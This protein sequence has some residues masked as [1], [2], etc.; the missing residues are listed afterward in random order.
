MGSPSDAATTETDRTTDLIEDARQ[1][2]GSD[3]D[4]NTD[5]D[6]DDLSPPISRTPR[7]LSQFEE[8]E[9][10]LAKHSDCFY[11]AKVI[12]INK[13]SYFLKFRV[14]VPLILLCDL[15]SFLFFSQVLNVEYKV[16]EWKYFVHYIVSRYFEYFVCR[17]KKLRHLF[18]FQ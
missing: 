11:E 6:G 15:F 1:D 3:T 9:K 7:G 12:K 17:I 10:V 8:G 18:I 2:S 4:S 5:C 14:F 13:Y 16:N